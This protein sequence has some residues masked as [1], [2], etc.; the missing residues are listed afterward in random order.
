MFSSPEPALPQFADVT[1]KSGIRF[2]SKSSATTQKY[3]PESMVGGVALL[4]FDNDGWLDVYL[5]NGAALRDPMPAGGAPD[6]SGAEYWNRLYRNNHDGTF[7]DVTEKAGV[8]GRGYGMGAAAGDY[9][10][11][12]WVDLYVTEL[13]GNTLYRNQG[14]GT[15]A[16]VT[17]AAGVE[18]GGWPTGAAFVDFDKDGKL[19]L[20][21]ARYLTWSFERNPW[22]GEKKP[23]YRAYCHPDQFA[24][25]KHA[26]FRNTGKGGFVDVSESSGVG[27]HPGK[28]LG[29]V[30][31]DFD[32]DEWPDILVANDS[33]GQQLF[34][35]KRDGTF[36][37]VGL[38]S[39]LA[40]DDDGKPFA[41]MGADAADYD[42][43]GW[44]DVFINALGNQRYALFRNTNGVFEY[45]S[46]PSGVA[47]ITQLHSGWGAKFIDYDN[48]GWM[49]LFVAQGHVMDNIELTQPSL[50]YNEPPLLMRNVEGK[51]RDVSALSGAP[52]GRKLAARG[53]AFGDLDNDGFVDAVL[54]VR[55]GGAVVLKNLGGNGNHWLTVSAPV[56]TKVRVAPEAGKEQVVWITASGSYLSS[57]DPRAHFGLGR[58][59]AARVVEAT[60]P[61]GKV[62]R[63][64]NV[65]AD[66][67]LAMHPGGRR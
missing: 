62:E 25:A 67:F 61:D 37:E 60:Y 6:K 24:P 53:A 29:V 31:L 46:G 50:R 32:R 39:G 42:R 26:L 9:D 19:D 7:A 43:D 30:V 16:D 58:S 8:R 17:K 1:A 22:C 18:A 64:E 21:V 10:G 33:V 49:D 3:L 2:Q 54:N 45:N 23:G 55:D 34:R 36:E 13:G 56:G 65:R 15:F 38:N 52:F 5:V 48:D 59:G 12:G 47:R 41:G 44:P 40:Y 35:S 27:K 51:F 57:N 66:Q 14:D 20:V 11:D 4:D 63:R 28:G